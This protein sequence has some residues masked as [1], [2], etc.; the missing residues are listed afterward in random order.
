M[1]KFKTGTSET[2][3]EASIKHALHTLV[4]KPWKPKT[5]AWCP[6]I[7]IYLASAVDIDELKFKRILASTP[8]DTK[9][10]QWDR[11][12]LREKDLVCYMDKER[13]K[14]VFG[15]TF[16]TLLALMKKKRIGGNQQSGSSSVQ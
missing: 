8:E 11:A 2:A 7:H 15:E 4:L 16:E 6:V 1:S 5:M 14:N 10:K 12:E 13:S 3:D 9:E